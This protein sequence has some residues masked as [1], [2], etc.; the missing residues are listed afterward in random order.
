M[1]KIFLI[2]IALIIVLVCLSIYQKSK[3]NKSESLLILINNK[4]IEVSYSKIKKL[5]Q[6]DLEIKKYSGYSLKEVLTSI[7]IKI[8]DYKE[9]T[10]YSIDGGRISFDE[11]ENFYLVFIEDSNEEY[12]RLV[13]PQDDFSQRWLKH[14]NKIEIN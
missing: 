2:L 5:Q 4:N 12:L 6:M 7:K 1:K 11:I 13:I 9:F 14:V 3:N 8:E 10:F